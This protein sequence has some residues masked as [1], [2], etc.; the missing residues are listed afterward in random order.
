MKKQLLILASALVCALPLC[1]AT[2]SYVPGKTLAKEEK[3]SKVMS[4]AIGKDDN[5]LIA[6]STMVR[7]VSP[8]TGE[9]TRKFDTGLKGI[10]AI[11]SD[12]N[13]I[14]VLQTRTELVE[15]ESNGK[16]IKYPNPVSVA[17]KVFAADG[18]FIKDLDLQGTRSATSAK[19]LNGKLY[20]ADLK[21]GVARIFNAD[22]GAAEGTI[23]KDMR[24]CCGIFDVRVDKKNNDVILSNLGAFK[25]QRYSADGKLISEFG[26]RGSDEQSFHGCC[27]PV[28]TEILS[29]GTILT[30][31]KDPARVKI[32]NQDGK[33]LHVFSGVGE[34]VKG[35][36]YVTLAVDSKGSV[37]LGVNAN[38]DHFVVQYLPKSS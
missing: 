30:V 25:V 9:C 27:N 29:D 14:W 38:S 21:G 15:R 26:K 34:L 31:E 12:G 19:V 37:Y 5:L 36:D 18:T 8:A 22:T 20:V 3:I 24:L 32:Y 2:L 13:Q 6:D 33:L 16:K 10:T 4:I 1:S 17:C 7:V 35:C 23:G 11:A 28:S